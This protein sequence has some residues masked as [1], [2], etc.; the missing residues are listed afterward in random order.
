MLFVFKARQ[1]A[2]SGLCNPWR[3]TED[4]A[5]DKQGWC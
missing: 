2:H 3:N 5:V 1:G 4:G